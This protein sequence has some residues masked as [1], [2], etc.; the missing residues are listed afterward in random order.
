MCLHDKQKKCHLIDLLEPGPSLIPDLTGMLM[1]FRKFRRSTGGRKKAFFAISVRG[2]DR[3]F[4]RFIWPET[5]AEGTWRYG[6]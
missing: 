1:R 4:L 2:E 6:D 3:P 5:L